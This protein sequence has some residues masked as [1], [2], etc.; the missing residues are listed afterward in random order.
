MGGSPSPQ[1]GGGK[2]MGPD[3]PGGLENRDQNREILVLRRVRPRLFMTTAL[4]RAGDGSGGPQMRD[5][6]ERHGEDIARHQVRDDQEY[7]RRR[8]RGRPLPCVWRLSALTAHVERQRA[9]RPQPAPGIPPTMTKAAEP[10]H[11]HSAGDLRIY[12]SRADRKAIWG[13][14]IPSRCARPTAFFVDPN[15]FAHNPVLC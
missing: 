10:Y 3:D 14:S 2:R 12:F 4:S 9:R 6:R 13:F 7:R 11:F 8:T 15:F 5:R 1:S